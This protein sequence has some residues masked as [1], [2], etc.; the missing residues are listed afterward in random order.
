[1][2]ISSQHPE[3]E[4]SQI[5][6]SR[7]R[8]VKSGSDAVKSGGDRYLPRLGGQSA[9]EYDNYRYRAMFL[10]V[11]ARTIRT[12]VGLST[13]KR[14][15]LTGPAVLDDLEESIGT[16][17]QPLDRLSASVMEEQ[18]SVGRV[19]ALV[20]VDPEDGTAPPAV[21]LYHAEN[22]INWDTTM[23]RGREVATTVVL[24]EKRLVKQQGDPYAREDEEIYRE[25]GFGI[26][27]A[28]TSP[29][30][31]YALRE[32]D[33][34]TG[35]YYQVIWSRPKDA[36]GQPNGDWARESVVV[37]RGAGGQPM[38]EIP[39]VCFN[40]GHLGMK[41]GEV[42]M[43]D[44]ATINLSH[45]LNSADL[46]HG[47]HFTALPTAWLAGF[48]FEGDVHIGSTRAWVTD[49]DQAKAGFLEFTGAGL[50]HLQEGMEQKERLMAVVGVRFLE[51]GYGGPEKPETLRLRQQGDR[52]NLVSMM[53]VT[54]DG[55]N[56]LLRYCLFFMTPLSAD[57]TIKFSMARDFTE[58]R[59][60]PNLLA[61]YINA[62]QNGLLSWESFVHV[63]ST[64]GTLP[65]GVDAD[66]EARR[67]M[68]GIPGSP[69]VAVGGE[70]APDEPE[71][72]EEEESSDEDE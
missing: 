69:T 48:E 35:V 41:I 46:E 56:R 7:V 52:A 11:V 54:E 65:D 13:F 47:R 37:P 24:R 66:E 62:V 71:E 40:A 25:L 18:V 53:D 45:Y 4:S 34:E 28:R 5:K 21:S 27:P 51:T 14:P 15:T 6:W 26:P 42:P 30:A 20:D 60:D 50:N 31:D 22:I 9:S 55:I 3:Y 64:T 70:P 36:K 43:D 33:L 38:K 49:N 61:Q 19:G 10:P 57:G 29:V 23:I 44:L 8:D 67:L 68:A 72:D 59:L 32:S 39:F 2:P 58:T 63:L 16:E 12:L 17:G 1:M